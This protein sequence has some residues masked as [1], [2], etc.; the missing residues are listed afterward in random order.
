MRRELKKIYTITIIFI[1]V[2]S[3]A[4]PN[5]N[6]IE[7]QYQQFKK[8]FQSLLELPTQNKLNYFSEFNKIYNDLIEQENSFEKM[9]DNNLTPQRLQ[10]AFDIESLR[11]LEI[12]VIGK[13]N[14]ESCQKAQYEQSLNIESP[15]DLQDTNNAKSTSK[16]DIVLNKIINNLCSKQ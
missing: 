12:I 13:A 6:Q 4:R 14:K 5:Q 11:P 10:M 7:N 1:S 9:L 3:Y 15:D 8:T 2:I 16:I